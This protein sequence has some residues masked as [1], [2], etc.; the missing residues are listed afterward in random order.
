LASEAAPPALIQTLNQP[1][2]PGLCIAAPAK[3]KRKTQNWTLNGVSPFFLCG[4]NGRVLGG[5]RR[6]HF[7]GATGEKYLLYN[8]GML[9]KQGQNRR[10]AMLPDVGH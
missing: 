2:D 3:K 10:E 1:L 9:T 7:M 4:S 6:T 5:R 8:S